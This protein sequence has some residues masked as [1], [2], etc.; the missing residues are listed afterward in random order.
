MLQ[1]AISMINFILHGR[2]LPKV[3]I[4]PVVTLPQ[5]LLLPVAEKSVEELAKASLVFEMAMWNY[6]TLSGN[7]IILLSFDDHILEQVSGNLTVQPDEQE[8]RGA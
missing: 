3:K 5:P 1:N 4:W 6:G 7:W 8:A 2:M